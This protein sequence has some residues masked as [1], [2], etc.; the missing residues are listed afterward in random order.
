MQTIRTICCK[1][2]PT[3]EQAVEIDATLQAFANACNHLVV[4]AAETQTKG[5]LALHKLAYRE[6]RK[7]FG[8][9][10]NLAVRAIGR[11]AAVKDISRFAPTSVSY[12]AR[13]FT[14]WE[15]DWTFGLTLL[16]GRQRLTAQLGEFQRSAMMGKVPTSATLVKRDGSY[17]LHVQIKDD[18]PDAVPVTEFLGVDLGIVQIATDSTGEG[19]SGASV[20][21]NR[22]RRMT[23]RKQYQR[24]GTKSAKHRLRKMSGRQARYQAWVNHAISKRLVGKAKTLG[25]GIALEELSGLRDRCEQTASRRFRRRLGN[26]SFF[27]LRQFVEYKARRAGVPVVTVDPRNSSRTC[28]VCGHCEKANRKSQSEFVCQQCGYSTNADLNAACNLR[29]RGEQAWAKS[30]LAQKVAGVSASHGPQLP[31]GCAALALSCKATGFSR[32]VVYVVVLVVCVIVM[33]PVA[34]GSLLGL[35]ASVCQRLQ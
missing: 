12:D 31:Q 24:K 28:N 18:S 30:K 8:L 19:F 34:S 20:E 33:V 22:K 25:I 21:R 17:F 2:T 14:F 11:V 6:T 7:L 9:S 35:T 1:L 13:I 4:M 29:S 3:A 16:H 26:W 27:Q 10:A 32:G 15:S 5:H 23:A